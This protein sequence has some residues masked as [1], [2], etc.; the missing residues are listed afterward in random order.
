MIETQNGLCSFCEVN[1]YTHLN[2]AYIHLNWLN[3]HTY[4]KGG[5]ICTMIYYIILKCLDTR[6]PTHTHTHTHTYAMNFDSKAHEGPNS[7]PL[8]ILATCLDQCCDYTRMALDLSSSLSNSTPCSI[9]IPT[10]LLCNII[11]SNGQ[12]EVQASAE[13]MDETWR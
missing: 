12:L 5:H 11:S 9:L 6:R 7:V 8:S 4:K 2:N 10:P 13:V 1:T 3:M